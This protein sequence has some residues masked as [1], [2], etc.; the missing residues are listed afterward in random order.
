ME[1]LSQHLVNI[2]NWTQNRLNMREKAGASGYEIYELTVGLGRAAIFGTGKW[3]DLNAG[4]PLT[5]GGE[6]LELDPEHPL[7]QIA[8]LG[9]TSL[10]ALNDLSLAM[11]GG[12]T[13]LSPERYDNLDQTLNT[14]A[15]GIGRKILNALYKNPIIT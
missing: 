6:K 8:L 15:Y 13:H 1:K 11:N 9:A 7:S 5:Y 4:T 14:I 2:G 3:L 10:G 12:D